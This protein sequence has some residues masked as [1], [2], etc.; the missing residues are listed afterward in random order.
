MSINSFQDAGRE[1]WKFY[2]N[3]SGLMT[4][5][6]AS[7]IYGTGLLAKPIKPIITYNFVSNL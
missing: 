4:K 2:L 6:A 3:G 1:G 5:M 7:S